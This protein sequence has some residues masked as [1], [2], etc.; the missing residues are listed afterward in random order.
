MKTP[1]GLV[2]L[3]LVDLDP[4]K[5][6]NEMVPLPRGSSEIKIIVIFKVGAH[7]G[8]GF[9]GIRPQ[10]EAKN[11]ALMERR[12]TVCFGYHVAVP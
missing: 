4:F 2:A 9:S 6:I 3:N 5:Q 1:T 7:S 11:Q 12:S 10:I 8:L